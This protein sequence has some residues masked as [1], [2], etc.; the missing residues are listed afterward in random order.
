MKG[1]TSCRVPNKKYRNGW[2]STFG[3]KDSVEMTQAEKI[4]AVNVYRS[5]ARVR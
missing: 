1:N 5:P 4:L 3:K 2:D